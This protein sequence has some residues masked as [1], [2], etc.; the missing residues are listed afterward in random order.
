MEFQGF[1][2]GVSGVEFQG[3]GG[4]W[5]LEVKMGGSGVETGRCVGS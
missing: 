4:G 5:V 3:F 2:G 1:G